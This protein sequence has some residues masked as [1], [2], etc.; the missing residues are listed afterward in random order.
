MRT[1]SVPLRRKIIAASLAGA[2]FAVLLGL[3]APDPFGE[4]PANPGGFLHAFTL[5][6]PVYLMYS[7]PVILLFGVPASLLADFLAARLSRGLRKPA[8]EP[9]ISGVLH[10]AF[11]LVALGYGVAAA[12]LGFAADRLLKKRPAPGWPVVLK[13]FAVPAFVWLFFM[14]IVYLKELPGDLPTLLQ[15]I[16]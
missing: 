11:G 14:F 8:A 15:A 2:A 1:A 4:Y 5:Y 7:F 10:A 3:L 16:L 13:S 12:L 6:V 9:V